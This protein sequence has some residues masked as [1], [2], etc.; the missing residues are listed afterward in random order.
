MCIIHIMIFLLVKNAI[1]VSCALHGR[2]S[3]QNEARALP[4]SSIGPPNIE[5]EEQKILVV[6]PKNRI[7]AVWP[8]EHYKET[9]AANEMQASGGVFASIVQSK[10]AQWKPLDNK[11]VSMSH[12]SYY[13]FS[14]WPHI[15]TLAAEIPFCSYCLRFTRNNDINENIFGFRYCWLR[16][17][18]KKETSMGNFAASTI[19]SCR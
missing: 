7:I 2:R 3:R 16:W 19:V 18:I 12:Y 6:I 17:I 14:N 5:L 4:H 11:F 8:M 9:L 10:G 13:Y 1:C 15:V